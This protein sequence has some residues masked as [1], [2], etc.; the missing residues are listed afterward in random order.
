MKD[1][2]IIAQCTKVNKARVLD[3]MTNKKHPRGVFC[4]VQNL[5]FYFGMID[6][7]KIGIFDSGLGGLTVMRQI[8]E[9]Y[10]QFDYVFYGDE[11]NLPYGSKEID[12]LQ[13]ITEGVLKY[14]YEEKGC[15][16]VVI[17]CNTVS[18]TL[19]DHLNT[20]TKTH[21]PDRH[22]LGIV[23][24]TVDSL[25][26]NEKYVVLG[27]PRTIR[28]H[29]YTT[30]IHN[31]YPDAEVSQIE[32]PLLA[33][34]IEHGQDATDYLEAGY[35]TREKNLEGATCV[36]A[37]T[38]YGLIEDD[39]KRVFGECRDFVRQEMITAKYVEKYIKAYDLEN[40]IS[41]DGVVEIIISKDN[42]TF[43][44]YANGWFPECTVEVENKV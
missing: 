37:C 32:F 10:P 13:G 24:A 9:L 15:V 43:R 6:K 4:L 30:F 35:S 5:L 25:P 42:P 38:H 1:A 16:I 23:E 22:L 28:S 7:G 27:T 17:A 3:K 29:A 2:K 44:R 31:K 14:L 33:G 21:Y 40:Q 36:L 20:W 12:E 34:Y 39:I 8:V 41:R 11:K 18:S 26:Q 19:Y